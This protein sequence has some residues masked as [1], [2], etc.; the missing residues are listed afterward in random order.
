VYQKRLARSVDADYSAVSI[1]PMGFSVDAQLLPGIE[2]ARVQSEIDRQLEK[3]KAELISERELVKAKNQVE[4]A[5]VFAQDSIFGQ[6]MKIGSYE[7]AGGWRQM[8][9]YLDGIRKVSREDIRRVA[10]Q[11]LVRDQRT[12]ATLIPTKEKP[13]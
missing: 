10:R 12:V 4:A 1:D 9:T 3:V 13:Q 11:Y 2:P 7:I 5:F 8:D 6:A